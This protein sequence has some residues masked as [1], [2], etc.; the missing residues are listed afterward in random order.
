MGCG[1]QIVDMGKEATQ[2]ELPLWAT[3]LEDAT[4]KKQ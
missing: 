3:A 2:G 1:I 4:R